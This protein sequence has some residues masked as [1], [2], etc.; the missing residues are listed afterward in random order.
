MKRQV[1]QSSAVAADLAHDLKSPISTVT[2]SAELLAGDGPLDPDRR[3]RLARALEQASEHMDRSVQGLLSLAQLEQHLA[4]QPRATLDLSAEIEQLVAHYRQDPATSRVS[5]ETK[6]ERGLRVHGIA[7]QLEQ[8]VRTLLDNAVAFGRARVALSL[9]PELDQVILRVTDDGP[10]ISAGNRQRL[11]RRFFTNRP[12]EAPPGTGLGLAIA[13]A[14]ALAHGGRI[15]CEP[16]GSGPLP[17]AS[18][19]VRLPEDS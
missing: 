2:A 17:G 15:E 4:S 3:Q 7:G 6:I 5:F 8:L 10:G 11:F 16:A 12:P 9:R 19:V 13:R 1:E 18:F 14:I